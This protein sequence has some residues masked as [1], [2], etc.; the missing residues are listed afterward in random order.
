MKSSHSI[1]IVLAFA[2]IGLSL[3][4]R[5]GEAAPA[6]EPAPVTNDVGQN[7]TVNGSRNKVNQHSKTSIRGNRHNGSSIRS[8]QNAEVNGERNKVRQST[9]SD[10]ANQ[11]PASIR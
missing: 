3:P 8:G 5:A 11:K 7:A 10:A 1:A 9:Q 2:T 6:V 4:A